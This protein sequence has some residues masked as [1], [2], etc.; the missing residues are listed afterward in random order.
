MASSFVRAL[1]LSMISFLGISMIFPGG[2]CCSICGKHEDITRDVCIIGGG[3]SGTYAAVRLRDK[4]KSV[5]V[6][7]Q[8][9]T[10]GGHT[11]TLIDPRTKKAIN[12]GVAIFDDLDI[13]REY[14]TRLGIKYKDTFFGN[15]PGVKLYANFQTGKIVDHKTSNMSAALTSYA[16][17]AMKYPELE[18][19]FIFSDPVPEDLVIPFS[20]FVEKYDIGD[21]LEIIYT[22]CQGYGDL[23]ERLTVYVL[24]TFDLAV[25]ND[26]KNGFLNPAS[27]NNNEIYDK[28]MEIIGSDVLFKSRVED[29]ERRKDGV[30][31]TVKTPSGRKTIHA[32]KLIISIPPTLHNLRPFGLDENEK[33]IFGQFKTTGYY[34]SLVRVPGLPKFDSMTNYN[35][36]TPYNLPKLP[37]I[38][39][40]T[41]TIIPDV[42]DVKYGSPR[43]LREEDVKKDII[44]KLRPFQDASAKDAEFVAWSSH[45]PFGA[46]VSRKA[47]ESGFYKKLYSLQGRHNTYWTG[48]AFH[49]HNSGLL[50]EYTKNLVD[51]LGI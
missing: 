47:I 18:K 31:L 1:G 35:P 36:D 44:R 43:A 16:M 21:A 15:D 17:Q 4:G 5:V 33:S 32:K 37:D 42:Y 26:L 8:D 34:T 7:E 46:T 14:F 29:A 45:T 6:I 12:F 3:S 22:Y 19:G 41:P 27:G 39:W 2:S 51:T 23:L 24:K 11:D 25:L 50:W 40:I 20:K 13:T 38:Y 28:A 49:A 10:L 30:K 48:S 9:E